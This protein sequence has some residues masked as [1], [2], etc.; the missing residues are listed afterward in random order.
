MLAIFTVLLRRCSN[1]VV[2]V[3]VGKLFFGICYELLIL[4]KEGI[5]RIVIIEK[6]LFLSFECAF[7]NSMLWDYL[8]CESLQFFL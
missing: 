7:H 3:Y 8:L 5:L 2:R 4:E 1:V 6:T